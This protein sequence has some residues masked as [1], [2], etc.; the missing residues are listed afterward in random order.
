MKEHLEKVKLLARD[1][2]NGKEFPRSARW[3]AR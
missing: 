2:W 1:L 3:R